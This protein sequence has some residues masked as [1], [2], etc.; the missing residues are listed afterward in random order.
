V[1]A[2]AGCASLEMPPRERPPAYTPVELVYTTD[3]KALAT[4]LGLA[5]RPDP[6]TRT[7]ALD[8]EAGR[9]VF[10]DESRSV[11][12][13]GKSLRTRDLL[14]ISGL[15]LPLSE[16]DAAAVRAA[17]REAQRDAAAAAPPAPSSA[18]AARRPT[19][20]G[21]AAWKVPLTRKWEGILIHHSATE[22]GNLAQFDKYHREVNKWLGV[23]YDFIICNGQGGPDGLVETTF[24]WRDQ[25]QGA[26]AGAGNKWHNEHWVG[27]CLVGDFNG[28]R[29]TARQMTSLRRLVR[30]LQ[31][32]CDIP[33][34][35]ILGHRD[36]RDT[37]CPGSHFPLHEVLRDPPR[38]K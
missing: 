32:Y 13:A 9:V 4:E 7:L 25:I 27:I 20:A 2:A 11:V 12:V 17:W 26:H 6:R 23:G 19:A 15:D 14:R 5:L 35:N 34:R 24:R 36:I 30:F 22:S 29:P 18:P 16:A 33:D 10:V 28:S 1:V 31:D 8:G 3:A 37:D 38:A 21:D